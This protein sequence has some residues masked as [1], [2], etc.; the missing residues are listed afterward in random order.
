MPSPYN[1]YHA[2][3][4]S[5]LTHFFYV[6]LQSACCSNPCLRMFAGSEI[7][8]PE[9][10]HFVLCASE[11]FFIGRF[12][13]VQMRI[14]LRQAVFIGVASAHYL[15]CPLA[16]ISEKQEKRRDARMRWWKE[17]KNIKELYHE[18]FSYIS[19]EK[20]GGVCWWWWWWWWCGLAVP[21][22][23]SCA[24]C[25]ARPVRGV[26]DGGWIGGSFFNFSMLAGRAT[27]AAKAV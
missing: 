3:F 2:S 9:P 16:T 10:S 22:C 8:V 12:G 26:I 6:G 14:P 19:A 17:R 1:S 4:L 15:I 20:L 23:S 27:F 21:C 13:S 5:L 18:G 11:F 24:G 7:A 25:I